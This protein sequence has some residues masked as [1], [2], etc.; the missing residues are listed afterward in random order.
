VG[1]AI[2]KNGNSVSVTN[3]GTITGTQ[4]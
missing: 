4:S 2:R 1:Y 3:N